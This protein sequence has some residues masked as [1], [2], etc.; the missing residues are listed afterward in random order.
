MFEDIN[1]V[2]CSFTKTFT[3]LEP[4]RY[5]GYMFF[6][7]DCHWMGISRLRWALWRKADQYTKVDI[8]SKLG[9]DNIK[10]VFNGLNHED[11]E[12]WLLCTK[13]QKFFNQRSIGL[14]LVSFNVSTNTFF[15]L[16]KHGRR[17]FRVCGQ[18]RYWHLIIKKINDCEIR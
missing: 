5:I 10:H 14:F 11:C 12:L 7:L 4:T 6:T 17:A 9:H 18:S 1:L 2:A 16:R 8:L 13:K 15:L 3:N